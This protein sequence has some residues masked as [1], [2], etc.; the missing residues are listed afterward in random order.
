MSIF[1]LFQI[2]LSFS[3]MVLGL[4]VYNTLHKLAHFNQFL[5]P[6]FFS[7][8]FN[9]IQFNTNQ[10]NSIQINSIIF[11][12]I[13]SYFTSYVSKLCPYLNYL[14]SS[15]LF[16]PE[17]QVYI[18]TTPCINKHMSLNFHILFS[19]Q[20]DSIQ[21]IYISKKNMFKNIFNFELFQI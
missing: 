13:L 10:F 8:Q 19:F 2:L 3:T 4:H 14:R 18:F 15:F 16:P 6:F 9:S 5:Y 21:F 11:C 20:I 7:I 17:S 1:E 12:S